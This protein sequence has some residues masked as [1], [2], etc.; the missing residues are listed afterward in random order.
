VKERV[1][2]RSELESC[3]RHGRALMPDQL[4]PLL[5]CI[6]AEIWVRSWSTPLRAETSA[7]A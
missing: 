5:A 1:L 2:E 6:A 3:L 4:P 7:G